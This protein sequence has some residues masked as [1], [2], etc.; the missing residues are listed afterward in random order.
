MI[1]SPEKTTQTIGRVT[2]NVVMGIDKAAIAHVMN[3]LTDLYSD[4]RLAVIREYSTN[5]RDSHVEAGIPDRPIEISL[6]ST[7]PSSS[8]GTFR[9]QDFGVGLNMAEIEQVYSQYGAS[10]KRSSNDVN[11]MLGLGC[12]SGL[13]YATQFTITSVKD[14]QRII[15]VVAKNDEGIGTIQVLAVVPTTDPN[16]V[17]IEIP[18]TRNEV[19]QFRKTAV[20]F[21]ESWE[22]GT[23]LIDG[24]APNFWRDQKDGD[25]Q[26]W[27]T[28]DI[29]VTRGA[30]Y[31]SKSYI[32]MGGVSYPHD[33]GIS[34]CTI[35]A[36]VPIGSADFVPA[37]ENLHY[38]ERTNA[39]VKE[40]KNTVNTKLVT[41]I[42]E[43]A[44]GGTEFEKNNVLHTW[45][46]NIRN[47]QSS[48]KYVSTDPQRTFQVAGENARRYR[49]P[50]VQWGVFNESRRWI[51]SE[52]PFGSVGPT[53]KRRLMEKFG[54]GDPYRTQV[55]LFPPTTDLSAIQGHPRLVSW[56][57]VVKTTT[58]PPAQKRTKTTYVWYKGDGNGGR[59]SGS[60][61]SFGDGTG[62]YWT[63]QF[64]P[65]VPEIKQVILT[66]RQVERFC[67]NHPKA[68]KVST[69]VEAETAKV[70]ASLTD[71]DKLSVTLKRGFI[72]G[73]FQD[74]TFLKAGP[75][76]LDPL[77]QKVIALSGHQSATLIR[78]DNLGVSVTVDEKIGE[79]IS[80][81]YPLLSQFRS[82]RINTPN[83]FDRVDI[84]QD[85]IHYLNAKYQALV[86]GK[87]V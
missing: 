45:A 1:P 72:A 58:K 33:F 57:E 41:R 44:G 20:S 69:Y 70:L 77:L 66:N 16:G 65:R 52:Y 42:L 18:V 43:V 7:P 51:V 12:K 79:T 53:H 24:S 29:L 35:H 6:P 61:E 76:L 26:V 46:G 54:G 19:V 62:Y 60:A 48:L 28:P 71:D 27:V 31:N 14:G 87:Q 80:G 47:L 49:Y 9:V 83:S 38:T 84:T 10:T 25:S 34:G 86:A 4:P 64:D 82:T 55:L 39:V 68:E 17:T 74:R 50:N 3:V 56:A 5:A 13:T 81:R 75:L 63:T 2:A 30:S 21:F 32:I 22:P 85:L 37:R 40:I 8:S 23:V 11:G 78:A 73:P 67:K 15:A 59:I 36:W